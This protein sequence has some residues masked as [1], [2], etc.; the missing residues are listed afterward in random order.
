MFIWFKEI[1]YNTFQIHLRRRQ[2]WKW[3]MTSDAYR[4]GMIPWY[5]YFMVVFDFCIRRIICLFTIAESL[6]LWGWLQHLLM[7]SELTDG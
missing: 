3:L 1:I 7:V 6:V 4:Y 2:F 5:V